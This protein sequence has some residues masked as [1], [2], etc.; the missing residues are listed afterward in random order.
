[1]ETL[2]FTLLFALGYAAAIFTWERAQKWLVGAEHYAA[3]LRDKVR[4]LENELR[5]KAGG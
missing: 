3:G 1:M 2:G 5:T 4:A